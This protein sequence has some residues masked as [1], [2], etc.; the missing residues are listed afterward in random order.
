MPLTIGKCPFPLIKKRKSKCWTDWLD[1]FVSGDWCRTPLLHSPPQKKPFPLNTCPVA[2]I[3]RELAIQSAARLLLNVYVDAQHDEGSH[4]S[5]VSQG[6]HSLTI[7]AEGS[8]G[9]GLELWRLAATVEG[10]GRKERGVANKATANASK[11][12]GWGGGGYMPFSIVLW[13]K[14]GPCFFFSFYIN[15]TYVT[16][17][18]QC[19]NTIYKAIAKQVPWVVSKMWLN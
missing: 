5:P 3:T 13:W 8:V 9:F 11:L 2:V 17:W 18:V 4:L 6:R 7:T 19:V 15:I 14:T 16:V 10:R 1:D 12:S